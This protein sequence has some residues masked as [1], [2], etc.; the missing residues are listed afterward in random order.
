MKWPSYNTAAIA[1]VEVGANLKED[2]TYEW[3][4]SRDV[5][6]NQRVS[7]TFA[8]NIQLKARETKESHEHDLRKAWLVAGYSLL[9]TP[10]VLQ[11]S[12]MTQ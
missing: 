3:Y 10:M 4:E 5:T 6:M 12:G 1:R 9:A 8:G 2:S 11:H 7:D